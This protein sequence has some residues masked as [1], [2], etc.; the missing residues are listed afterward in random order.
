MR[1]ELT[2]D[3]FLAAAMTGL[4]RRIAAATSRQQDRFDS[5]GDRWELDIEAAC[6]ERAAAKGLNVY[7]PG[8]VN[9]GKAPS[10]LPGGWEVR[11]S[12]RPDAH[13]IVRALDDPG[14]RYLLVTGQFGMYELHGWMFGR[15][16]RRDAWKRY[17]G[18][19]FFVPQRF[20]RPVGQLSL[21]DV[22]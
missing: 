9:P 16:A 3:E 12:V 15:D 14:R 17:E 22:A 5:G 21:G 8:H 18:A 1:V 4:S 13:L 20:L 10:D 11:W 19:A 7:W 2:S 6:A